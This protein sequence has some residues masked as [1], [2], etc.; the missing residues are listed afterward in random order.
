MSYE[1]TIDSMLKKQLLQVQQLEKLLLIEKEVLQQHNPDELLK[2]SHQKTDLLVIIDAT[3]KECDAIPDYQTLVTS[4]EFKDVFDK[5]E[6][7]LANCKS[8]NT[9]NGMI[10]Q[11]SSLAIERMQSDLIESRSKSSMTYD[12]KGKKNGGLQGKSI[13]A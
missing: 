10:I 7:A 3:K 12:N 8:L 1:P 2:V 5:I 13:K 4:P 9:V 11:Q 6:E